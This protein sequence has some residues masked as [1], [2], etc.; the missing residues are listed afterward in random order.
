ML[1]SR[2]SVTSMSSTPVYRSSRCATFRRKEDLSLRPPR[3]T[4]TARRSSTAAITQRRKSS[5][6][7]Q[8]D[9]FSMLGKHDVLF[10][11]SALG[12][13]LSEPSNSPCRRLAVVVPWGRSGLEQL[14]SPAQWHVGDSFPTTRRQHLSA[15]ACSER[16]IAPRATCP[17][18]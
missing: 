13:E 15:K 2:G 11:M 16:R 3:S 9:V 5:C 8:H 7:R 14:S 4:S 1:R 18:P 10:I 6:R 17:T 12:I